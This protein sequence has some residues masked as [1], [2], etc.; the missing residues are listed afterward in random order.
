MNNILEEIILKHKKKLITEININPLNLINIDFNFINF[1]DRKIIYIDNNNILQNIK[2]NNFYDIIFNSIL[3]NI[4][5]FYNI[6][7]EK[8]EFDVYIK[9]IKN[10][11][12][13]LNSLPKSL[14]NIDDINFNNLFYS[15][16]SSLFDFKIE[17]KDYENLNDIYKDNRN[18]YV[19]YKYDKD[20]I[21]ILLNIYDF[22][23]KSNYLCNFT[24]N[25]PNKDLSNIYILN[26][27]LSIINNYKIYNSFTFNSFILQFNK[28]LN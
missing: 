10:I 17:K 8:Y 7:T 11:Q 28:L 2:I 4:I 13:L 14:F 16:F 3:N 26:A 25:I 1:L 23:F 22:I 9:Y 24:L 20:F 27:F 15:L 12:Y 5:S 18:I 21:N 19:F 6:S